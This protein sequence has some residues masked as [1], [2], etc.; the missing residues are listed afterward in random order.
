MKRAHEVV[1]SEENRSPPSDFIKSDVV[2]RP[3]CT[4]EAWI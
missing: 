1:P 3:D 2:E 4:I